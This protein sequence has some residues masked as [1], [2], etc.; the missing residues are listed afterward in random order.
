MAEFEELSEE[1][2][3]V[4]DAEEEDAR[5]RRGR[6]GSSSEGADDPFWAFE[7]VLPEAEGEYFWIIDTRWP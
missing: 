2:S 1:L 4:E 3:E 5:F 7:E 6:S